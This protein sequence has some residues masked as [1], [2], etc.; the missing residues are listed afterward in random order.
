MP[1]DISRRVLLKAGA[2]GAAIA[3]FP[4]AIGAKLLDRFSAK[5]AAEFSLPTFLPLRNELFNVAHEGHTAALRL[6][7]VTDL[8]RSADQGN[9]AECFSLVFRSEV[10]PTLGQGTYRFFHPKLGSFAMFVAPVNRPL[11]DGS[12]DYEAI[13]NRMPQTF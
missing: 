2:V 6:I 3:A 9:H 1:M 5:S 4:V 10:N 12:V 7:K 8:I 11:P 13:F